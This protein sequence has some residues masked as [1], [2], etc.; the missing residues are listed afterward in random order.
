MSGSAEDVSSLKLEGM[1][2][3]I[4]FETDSLA[5]DELTLG[6]SAEPCPAEVMLL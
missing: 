5:S 6:V 3:M 1:F 4:R 2:G